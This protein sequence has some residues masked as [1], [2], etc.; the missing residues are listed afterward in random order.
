MEYLPGGTAAV[1]VTAP[2]VVLSAIPVCQVPDCVTVAFVPSVAGAPLTVPPAAT[3]AI[4]VDGVPATAAPVCTAGMM[5][6]LTVTVSVAVAQSGVGFLSHS[7]YGMAYVPGGTAA[8][9]VT[10]PVVVLRV[11]PVCHVPDCVTVA[12][13]PVP[14]VAAAPLTVPPA[15]TLAIG[16][17]GVPATAVPVCAAGMMLALTLTVSVAVA[18]SG[19]GFLSHSWYLSE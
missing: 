5:L 7:A 9:V 15:A 19:V 12:L 16:V 8:V 13:P 17:D 18:Q 2:L 1:V 10:A 3:L 11:I 6:A 14:R 4:G